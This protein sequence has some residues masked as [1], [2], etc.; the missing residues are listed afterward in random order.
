MAPDR[1]KEAQISIL[2]LS[3]S[4]TILAVLQLHCQHQLLLTTLFIFQVFVAPFQISSDYP[5]PTET[6]APV[7][8]K[9]QL[10]VFCSAATTTILATNLA[11]LDTK[12]FICTTYQ[13]CR[14]L[15]TCCMFESIHYMLML[16][17]TYR[18]SLFGLNTHWTINFVFLFF[19][20][21]SDLLSV[22]AEPYVKA[23]L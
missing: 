11:T 12:A 8:K 10:K 22:G 7:P 4:T 5:L 21:I 19:Y 13:L 1:R 15:S 20:F 3:N 6:A 9:A 14:L 23:L 17:S 18:V 2:L 16:T